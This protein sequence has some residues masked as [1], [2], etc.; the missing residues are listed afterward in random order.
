ML[1]GTD[2]RT[3]VEMDGWTDGRTDV[4]TDRQPDSQPAGCM[5]RQQYPPV[6]MAAEGKYV[7]WNYL[8]IPKLQQLHLWSMGKDK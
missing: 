5:E 1:F 8:S 3:D 2:R 7:R 6:L 4:R